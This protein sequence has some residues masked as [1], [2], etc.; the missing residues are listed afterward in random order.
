MGDIVVVPASADRFADLDVILGRKSSNSAACWCL[1]YR[2]SSAENRALTAEERPQLVRALCAR[3]V[4]PGVLA[5]LGGEVAGWAGV[6]PR[7][8]LHSFAHS[9]RI[10]HVDDLP[11]W[12]V[13]CFRVRAGYGRRGV[14]SA[15]LAGAVAFAEEHGAPAIE[16]YPVDNEGRRVD[17]TM[18]YV[19]TRGMFERAGFEK[20]ADT[21]SVLDGFPRVLMRR[22]LP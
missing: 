13:W 11:V 9:R 15:L 12:T 10:P 14:A 22:I 19:G 3:P 7:A 2:L 16:G 21:Q 5:Y 6:A 4:P 8:E 20:A 1:S 17:R 18:A